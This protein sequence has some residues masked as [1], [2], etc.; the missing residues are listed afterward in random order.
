MVIYDHWSYVTIILGSVRSPLL[1]TITKFF[2]I[3]QYFESNI[4][5]LFQS[6][7]EFDHTISGSL[8]FIYDSGQSDHQFIFD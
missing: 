4:V 6:G 5:K 1:V 3:Y 2:D 8:I 7:I